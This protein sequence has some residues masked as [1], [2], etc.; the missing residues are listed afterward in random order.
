MRSRIAAE[1]GLP[2][3]PQRRLGEHG[4]DD[5]AAVDRRARVVAAHR[6]LELAEDVDRLGRVGAD[7]AQRAAALAVQAH[8]LRER[9]GDEERERPA[10]AVARRGERA[11]RVG[12]LD[13]AVAEALVGEVEVGHAA[14]RS[15]RIGT[16]RPTA[17]ASGRRRSGCGSTRAAGRRSSRGRP[18]QRLAHR[19]ERQAAGRA[20][21]STGRSWT[22]RPAPSNIER[23]FSQLGS[24][25]QTS[26][27]GSQRAMKSAPTLRPPL[28][29][30]DWI[31]ATRPDGDRLVAGAEQQ[32]LHRGAEVGRAF[33][34]QVGL[35][36]VARDAP[37]ARRGAP[38]RA[39][40][41]GRRRRSRCRSTG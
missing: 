18:A 28:E 1:L 32:R 5:L 6:E 36:R 41:C 23:W 13:D 37:A 3:A 25:T 27:P 39:P 38:S 11:Q 15:T 40:G 8:A 26:L 30:T 16:A 10:G 2:V 35:G 31:V 19:V 20:R 22:A 7:D 24:L 29:P 21:R 12:V 9:V 4:G 17:P 14:R 33:D 34:R